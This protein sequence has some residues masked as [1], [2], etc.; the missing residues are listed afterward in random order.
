MR[1]MPILSSLTAFAAMSVM[2]AAMA[3]TSAASRGRPAT[4]KI[5]PAKIPGKPQAIGT[6]ISLIP[7]KPYVVFLVHGLGGDETTFGSFPEILQTEFGAQNVLVERIV[8]NTQ[9]ST[10]S[11]V[12]FTDQIAKQMAEFYNKHGLNPDVD[13]FGFIVHSQGGIMARVYIAECI[14]PEGTH[15]G[16]GMVGE[17]RECRK[18]TLANGLANPLYSPKRPTLLLTLGTPHWGSQMGNKVSDDGIIGKVLAWVSGKMYA[19]NKQL[20]VGSSRMWTDRHTMIE[21]VPYW[22]KKGY[23]YFLPGLRFVSVA[24]NVVQDGRHFTGL[25]QKALNWFASEDINEDD[26][27]VPTTVAN[28]AF[29]YY[30]E[31]EIEGNSRKREVK[32]G[33]ISMANETYLVRLPHTDFDTGD[34]ENEKISDKFDGIASPKLRADGSVK[35]IGLYYALRELAKNTFKNEPKATEYQAKIDAMT[36]A[37]RGDAPKVREFSSE[38]IIRMPIG[39][40]RKTQLSEKHINDFIHIRP[41]APQ[42]AREGRIEVAAVKNSLAFKD[43]GFNYADKDQA[44]KRYFLFL[45]TGRFAEEDAAT[46]GNPEKSANLCYEMQ[47]PGFENKSFCTVVRP[48]E[49]TFSEIILSPKTIADVVTG[50]EKNP[51]LL[52]NQTMVLGYDSRLNQALT[53]SQDGEY[54]LKVISGGELEGLVDERLLGNDA[55]RVDVVNALAESCYIGEVGEKI[56]VH[57]G[58]LYAGPFDTEPTEA[59]TVDEGETVRILGRFGDARDAKDRYLIVKKKK[60]YWVNLVD[61]DLTGGR[62]D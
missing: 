35:H 15:A 56:G 27:I 33:D 57:K 4:T 61:V 2:T 24:G 11:A 45:H 62:C 50:G 16:T 18:K 29:H 34:D 38:V 52:L 58:E 43:Y 30:L 3:Q 5:Q 10:E 31:S 48:G 42:N 46:Y 49:A 14:R 44:N 55:R 59:A 32:E 1:T 8:Y 17:M 6:P 28:P 60:F 12:Q 37:G 40:N 26:V 7:K 21:S 41:V 47:I 19:Q 39:Y 25:L 13:P 23:N 36:A 9:S 53:V 51:R 20:A 54:A 22:K